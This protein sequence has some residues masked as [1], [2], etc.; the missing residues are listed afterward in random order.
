[1][2]QI[3]RIHELWLKCKLSLGSMTY[4]KVGKKR[5]YITGILAFYSINYT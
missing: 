2:I 5:D 4:E 3:K 1:M